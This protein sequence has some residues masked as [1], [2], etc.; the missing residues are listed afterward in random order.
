MKQLSPESGELASLWVLRWSARLAGLAL[1]A[2][3]ALAVLT[4]LSATLQLTVP[5]LHEGAILG[6]LAI[7]ALGMIAAWR[8]EWQGAILSIAALLCLSFLI[9]AGAAHVIAIGM[10]PPLLYLMDWLARKLRQP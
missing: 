9:H 5:S 7:A 4:D 6:M 2:G 1:V 8:W 10:I 3:L